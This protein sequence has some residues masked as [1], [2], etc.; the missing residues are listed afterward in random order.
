MPL[1]FATEHRSIEVTCTIR[2]RPIKFSPKNKESERIFREITELDGVPLRFKC[3]TDNEHKRVIGVINGFPVW[4]EVSDIKDCEDVQSAQRIMTK[5]RNNNT[6]I[7]VQ[8]IKIVFNKSQLPERM[9]YPDP[10]KR[11][12]CRWKCNRCNDTQL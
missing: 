12:E 6:L 7:P 1:A 10:T 11:A 2:N 5:E 4:G 8:A 3:I 9:L